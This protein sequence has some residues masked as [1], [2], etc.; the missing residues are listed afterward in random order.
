MTEQQ[1]ASL[2]ERATR[3]MPWVLA[4]AAAFVLSFALGARELSSPD[5]TRY[6]AISWSML[7]T[8]DWLTPTHNL[9]FKHW[10]K[11]PLTYW[12]MASS[13]AVLGENDWA[14]R[15]PSALAAL[16]AVMGVYVIGRTMHGARTGFLAG[17]VLLASPLFFAVARLANTDM[18]LCAFV[19]WTWVCFVRAMFG[20]RRTK[21]WFV[22]GGLCAGLGFMTKG[23]VLL[24][25]TAAP[26]LV[27]AA[28]TNQWRRIGWWP[29]LAAAG[30]F[31]VV[32]LPWY[33]IVSAR[34]PGLLGYF[35]EYQT[36]HRMTTEVH[37]RTEPFWFFVWLVPL[38]FLPWIVM[39]PSEIAASL[40]RGV[41]GS[42]EERLRVLVPV[43][44]AVVVFIFIS[45]TTSKL[46][47]YCL[48][49]FPALALLVGR[50][51]DHALDGARARRSVLWLGVVMLAMAVAAV[52]LSPVL[53]AWARV[54][55]LVVIHVVGA[56]S[57]FLFGAGAVLAASRRRGAVGVVLVVVG[58]LLPLMLT[59]GLVAGSEDELRIGN[60]GREL[61]ELIQERMERDAGRYRDGVVLVMY[62]SYLKELPY[63]LD[64]PVTCLDCDVEFDY[65]R[66]DGTKVS[67]YTDEELK[68]LERGY[69]RWNG[70]ERLSHMMRLKGRRLLVVTDRESYEDISASFLERGQPMVCFVDEVGEFVICSNHPDKP[71]D[72]GG[73]AG[74]EV[75]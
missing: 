55:R 6:A 50:G 66:A 42:R 41:A 68:A 54:E 33:V 25:A 40:R 59:A 26:M 35:L 44:W 51:L 47:T 3:W 19:V 75:P 73:G 2:D 8:G 67:F 32:A 12:L 74:D 16:A 13:F 18:P 15:V 46:A 45:L 14:A 9:K 70:K 61:A 1:R 24:M 69:Y 10:H 53:F 29:W 34:N 22:L 52:A 62:R 31:L 60:E 23:P 49:L 21:L 63:Y 56:V 72:G 71:G 58:V 4:A 30:V 5:E 36:L 65:T 39:V 28:L 27:Y 43:V 48:P 37:K 38:G 7:E 57:F 11:P 64:M 20:A 17:L